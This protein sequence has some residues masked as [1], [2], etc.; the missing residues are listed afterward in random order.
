[1]SNFTSVGY[2]V[3]DYLKPVTQ[4]EKIGYCLLF[5]TIVPASVM[6]G[7]APISFTAGKIA[8]DLA[9]GALAYLIG[10]TAYQILKYGTEQKNRDFE[11]IKRAADSG[12]SECQFKLGKFYQ[13]GIGCKRNFANAFEYYSLATKQG[14]AKAQAALGSCYEH[15]IGCGKDLKK[16]FEN[17]GLAAKQNNAEGQAALG[18]CYEHGIHCEKDLKKAFEYYSLAA[19]QKNAEA[20]VSIG[21]C[22]EYGIY[23]EKDLKKAFHYYDL[24][25]K[26]GNAKGQAALGSCYECGIGCE[27]DIGQA[28]HYYGLA[29]KKQ[30]IEVRVALGRLYLSEQ[31]IPQIEEKL[32]RKKPGQSDAVCRKWRQMKA[33]AFFRDAVKKDLGSSFITNADREAWYSI[34]LI[35]EEKKDYKLAYEAYQWAIKPVEC[36]TDA[37]RKIRAHAAFRSAVLQEEGRT[38][39]SEWTPL[40]AALANYAIAV[41]EYKFLE[42]PEELQ[43]AQNAHLA[44][45][46]KLEEAKK[47]YADLQ[48]RCEVEVD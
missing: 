41:E 32:S 42:M 25:A 30:D 5:A 8:A 38:T 12:D 9:I 13:D 33:L 45:T 18:A 37:T 27:K 44:A 43:K 10:V 14:N 28:F 20:E 40:L 29:Y 39:T 17:Y 26:Q 36:E 16:A 23:C 35:D 1:M 31:K 2:T 15:E 6:I 21:R 48:K 47:A 3:Y 24:A 4:N 34:G 11:R 46:I 19:E 22:Y 7:I